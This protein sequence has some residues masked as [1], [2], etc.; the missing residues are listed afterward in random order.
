M[1]KVLFQDIA[2]IPGYSVV[3]TL[4]SNLQHS[5]LGDVI[6]I[7]DSEH[8]KA[9][10]KQLLG[11]VDAALMIAPEMGGLLSNRCR[12][13]QSAKIASWNCS[14]NSIDLCGDKLLLAKHL[15]SLGLPTI[16]TE[17]IDIAKPPH[18]IKWPVVLKPRDGAGSV[19]T[20]LVRNSSEWTDAIRQIQEC[21]QANNFVIQPYIHGQPLSVGVNI[22]FDGNFVETL[23]A[24]RQVLTGD[25]SFRYLG[26]SI[27]AAIENSVQNEIEQIVRATCHSIPGLAGYIGFDL[28]LTD[29]GH[30][31]IVEINPRLTTAYVGYRQFYESA[32]PDRWLFPSHGPLLRKFPSTP[33]EFRCDDF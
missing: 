7:Q 11:E 10:F 27:P 31:V 21:K 3:T 4:K 32:L 8:E 25:S 33:V 23:T 1:L 22:R 6:P 26:G 13:V 2:R 20:F 17:M 18:K 24:G 9:V 19:M 28:L 30:L 12:Q 29:R 14:P 15:Q 5:I 16:P